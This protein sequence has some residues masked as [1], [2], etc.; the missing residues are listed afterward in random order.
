MTLQELKHATTVCLRAVGLLFFWLI[1]LFLLT[2]PAHASP[3]LTEETAILSIIGEA[4]GEP[5]EGRIAVAEVIRR[6]GS[7][8]G[9]YGINAPRVKARKFSRAVY[10]ASK[11][12]WEASRLTNY[13]QGA[14][15]WGNKAD[16][17]KFKRAA[18]FKNCYIVKQIGNH[19]F[20][21]IK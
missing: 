2:R 8:K 3:P 11:Q 5:Q 12:A 4:E 19:Y 9:V 10:E 20:W 15:G 6:R 14:Q 17:Q 7:L 1:L 13:S 18:W 21:K 16:L